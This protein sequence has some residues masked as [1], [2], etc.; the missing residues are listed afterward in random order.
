MSLS[1]LS[2]GIGLGRWSLA[3]S[4][5]KIEASVRT[6]KCVRIL[7]SKANEGLVQL[8]CAKLADLADLLL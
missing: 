2:R 3:C 5:S 4:H 8:S 1:P 7:L 6:K